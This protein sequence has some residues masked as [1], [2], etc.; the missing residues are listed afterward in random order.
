MR[1]TR[2]RELIDWLILLV[3]LIL[4]CVALS[5]CATAEALTAAPEEWWAT[6]WRV[7]AAVL[8]DAWSAVSWLLPLG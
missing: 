8:Q 2:R 3:A 4:L 5:G 1:R 7:L 6:T